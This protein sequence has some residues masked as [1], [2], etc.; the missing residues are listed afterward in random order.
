VRLPFP[1]YSCNHSTGDDCGG[2]RLRMAGLMPVLQ[3]IG[4][5]SSTEWMHRSP[6]LVFPFQAADRSDTEW[7]DLSHTLLDSSRTS[8]SSDGFTSGTRSSS[9][10]AKAWFFKAS[11]AM[12][13]CSPHRGHTL[14]AI[15]QLELPIPQAPN[16]LCPG[17]L[18]S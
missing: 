14:E 18:E 3:R 13:Y 17:R 11:H 12:L 1:P 4:A 6:L 16:L 5:S 15:I 10:P 8:R 7:A 9:T 2:D